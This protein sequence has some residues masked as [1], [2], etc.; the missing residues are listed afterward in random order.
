MDTAI[1]MESLS[2][3][4]LPCG[5][6]QLLHG[7]ANADHRTLEFVPLDCLGEVLGV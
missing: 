7:K 5:T 3:C 1:D 6:L 4:R 2:W